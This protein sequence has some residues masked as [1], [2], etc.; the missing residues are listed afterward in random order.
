MPD[1]EE[2]PEEI[3]GWLAEQA[4]GP[5]RWEKVEPGDERILEDHEQ[6]E[7]DGGSLVR[8][9]A[10]RLRMSGRVLRDCPASL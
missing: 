1:V 6:R 2:G 7:L 10:P 8:G 9:A 4:G 5:G 3:A